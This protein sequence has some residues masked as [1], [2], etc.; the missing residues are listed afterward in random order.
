MSGRN[1]SRFRAPLLVLLAGLTWPPC[2]AEVG[3]VH[4]SED[5]DGYIV[6]LIDDPDPVPS[7][8]PITQVSSIR[9]VLNPEGSIRG[10]GAPRIIDHPTTGEPM[11]VWSRNANPGFDVVIS[12][13]VD[14]AWSEPQVIAGSPD[15]ELDPAIAVD[16]SD[17]SVHVVYS[18]LAQPFAISSRVVHTQAPADLSSWSTPVEVSQVGEAATHPFAAFHGGQLHVVYEA[19]LGDGPPY[20]ILL[21]TRTGAAWPGSVLLGTSQVDGAQP[22]IHSQG[23]E[24]WAEWIDAVGSMAWV[25][26]APNDV[27]GTPQSEGYTSSEDRDYFARGRIRGKALD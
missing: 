12:R 2:W 11:V 17:G 10:D 24:L 21:A 14:G 16:P 7:W 20:Y 19:A 6:S 25:E 1:V 22:E 18:V 3:A 15:A 9:F 23:G 26:R 4:V 8:R 5:A 27:W 13:F